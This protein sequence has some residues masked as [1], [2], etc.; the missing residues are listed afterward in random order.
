MAAG[1]LRGAWAQGFGARCLPVC[2]AEATCEKIRAESMGAGWSGGCSLLS[3]N[4]RVALT[5]NLP[6][7][8]P[9]PQMLHQAVLAHH[10]GFFGKPREVRNS[11]GAKA[12]V[13]GSFCEARLCSLPLGPRQSHH[14][15]VPLGPRQRDHAYGLTVRGTLLRRKYG[16]K[17]CLPQSRVLTVWGYVWIDVSVCRQPS[18]GLVC[19][20]KP[21]TTLRCGRPLRRCH[22]GAPLSALG[23]LMPCDLLLALTDSG[24]E[25][26]GER[27]RQRD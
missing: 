2:A 20:G 9:T 15:G 8:T 5:C 17:P 11:K 16:R 26:R 22:L 18:F 7:P 14:T 23:C 25:M 27:G 3:C 4:R 6:T 24:P 13:H 12:R 21:R 19:G 10:P 1:G